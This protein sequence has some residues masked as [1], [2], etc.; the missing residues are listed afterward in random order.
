M[1]DRSADGPAVPDLVVADLRGHGP[2]HAAFAGQHIIGLNV[3]V[4]GERA[5]RD[6]VAGVANVRQLRNATDVDEDGG[7]RQPELHEGQER[8]ASGEQFGIVAVLREL[9]DCVISRLSSHVVERGGNHRGCVRICS[10]A[11]STDSTMLW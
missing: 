6:V 5:N 8:H 1:S 2:Q 4:E 9:R 10:A 11:A 7:S 3:V